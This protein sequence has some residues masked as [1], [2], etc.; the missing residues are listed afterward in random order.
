MEDADALL[1]AGN[2]DG[3][4]IALVEIVRKQPSNEL[5][6]M[7]LFQLFAVMGEWDKAK[8]QLTTLAQL[9]SEAEM[10]SVAY[11]QAID[12][13]RQR[14]DVFAGK[15]RPIQHVAS[16]WAEPLMEAIEHF[17]NGRDEAGE[18][19]RATAFDAAPDSSG[20]LDGEAFD[21]IVD[22]DS[23]LGP[24]FELI[25]GGRY[26]I[27]PFDQ[28]ERIESAGAV[29]LRDLVWYPVQIAFKAGRSAAGLI[30]ARY[31][32]TETKGS[33]DERLARVTDWQDRSWGQAGIGQRLL[34]LS[35]GE[36]RGLLSLRTLDFA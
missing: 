18:S 15:V 31:P 9:S 5:A 19:A 4:R 13:E 3:A 27:Q 32:G 11:G 36:E 8:R 2:L 28:I 30:P 33:A 7:F 21:W 29:D 26:G 35:S 23:R 14:A 25:V 34:A 6:R 17:G 22:A 12:A 1:R 16:D 10:L 24:A 20:T